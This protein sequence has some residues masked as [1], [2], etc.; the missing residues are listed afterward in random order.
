MTLLKVD[1][2]SVNFKGRYRVF[3]WRDEGVWA[4][5]SLSFDME[6]A[7]LKGATPRGATPRGA[8]L[9]IVGE[10]G[11][12]KTTLLRALLGLVRPT[13]GT[14]ELWGRD[15]EAMSDDERLSVRRR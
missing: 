7:M 3:K 12:G 15:L 10:S 6:E 11:S 9:S 5:K 8:T 13:A 1:G 14:V 2:L 4:L